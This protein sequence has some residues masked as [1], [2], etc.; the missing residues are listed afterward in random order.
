MERFFV[1]Q[2]KQGKEVRGQDDVF[3]IIADSHLSLM[4]GDFSG[5][6][7]VSLRG[8]HLSHVAS[9][10]TSVDL[11]RYEAVVL[12][13]GGNDLAGRS[14]PAK[15]VAARLMDVVKWLQEK[16]AGLK[17]VTGSSVPR[18]LRSYNKVKPQDFIKNA[19][20]LDK[21]ILK[22]S[23]HHYHLKFLNCFLYE[24]EKGLQLIYQLYNNHELWKTHLNEAGRIVFKG[25]INVMV[26]ALIFDSWQ[27][28]QIYTPMGPKSVMWV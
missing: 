26:E 11:S 1:Y 15:D 2:G 10:L 8:A 17:V 5:M 25:V 24:G 19:V 22:V 28:M 4:H 14:N 6:T 18:E 7:T 9:Y 20:A 16:W 12:L 27:T 3:M 23:G 21:C 13:V